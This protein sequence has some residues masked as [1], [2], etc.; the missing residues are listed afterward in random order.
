VQYFLDRLAELG[1]DVRELAGLQ[2]AAVGRKTAESLGEY[3]LRADIVPPDFRAESLAAQLAPDASGKKVMIVRA[4]RGRDVLA[5]TL[6]SA[7]AV[8]T[9]VVAYSHTDVTEADPEIVQ[10]ARAGKIDWVTITSSATA[11]SLAKMLGDSLEQI[12]I[13]SLSPVTS[14][15][16]MDLGFEVAVEANPYTIESLIESIT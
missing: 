10:L 1:T 15:T 9:Q 4:S 11:E 8:V 14:K 13:A 7:G 12:K 5:E 6:T 2:I 3:H 16:I